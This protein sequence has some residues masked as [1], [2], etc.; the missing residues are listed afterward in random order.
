TCSDEQDC[1]KK[2]LAKDVCVA[3]ITC[4]KQAKNFLKALEKGD[5]NDIGKKYEEMVKCTM[6]FKEKGEK[7]F[8]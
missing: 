8:V 1:S 3:E 7:L 2:L 4:A 5:E 6:E